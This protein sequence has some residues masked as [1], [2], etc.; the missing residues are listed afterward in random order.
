MTRSLGEGRKGGARR[1]AAALIAAAL[2]APCP[3]RGELEGRAE[4][5]LGL[6]RFEYAEYGGS[7][8]L[9]REMGWVPAVS[10]EAELRGQRLFGRA[11]ARLAQGN[12]TYHGRTQSLADPNLDALPVR[13]KTDVS[14]VSGELQGGAFLD[15]ARR[16]G[17]FA[18]AGARR[19]TRDIRDAAVTARDGTPALVMGL[20]EI[21]SWYELQAGARWTFLALP[22]AAWDLEARLVRTAGAEISVD[23]ARGFGVGET[24]RMGLG[25]RTGWRAATTLRQDLEPAVFLVVSLFA[26]GS[27]FGASRP[28]VF[29]DAGGTTRALSE[30][31]SETL[32]AGL[33]VGI[34]GRY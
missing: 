5:R 27:A 3:A 28:F 34:G 18:A 4:L 19:W 20:S 14:F 25:A 24:A 33:E 1:G 23:L 6:L 22:R 29:Q 11:A 13:S 12:V 31:R 2:L 32:G 10:G 17:V 30:P 9:D 21:Y 26:E 15:G 16:L 7:V 8:S